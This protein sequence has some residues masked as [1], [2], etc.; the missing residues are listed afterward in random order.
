MTPGG[1]APAAAPHYNDAVHHPQPLAAVAAGFVCLAMGVHDACRRPAASQREP[2][3]AGVLQ[4]LTALPLPAGSAVTLVV[5][6]EVVV[7]GADGRPVF[8]EAVSR[9]PDLLWSFSPETGQGTPCRYV[10]VVG[11]TV[12]PQPWRRVWR[13]GHLTLL[14]RLPS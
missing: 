1:R 12:V 7:G 9:R 14:E 11:P 3:F 4:P 13:S 2:T 6:P 5:P 8:F 10:V